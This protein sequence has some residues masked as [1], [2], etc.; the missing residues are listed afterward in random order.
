MAVRTPL[1]IGL[2]SRPAKGLVA[3]GDAIFA[4]EWDGQVLLAI[5]DGLGHGEE[6]ARVSGAAKDWLL[7]NYG[8]DVKEIV[9]MLHQNLRATRGVAVALTK[10]DRPHRSLSFCGIGNVEVRVS[11]K[12]A[13][14]PASTDGI[15]GMSVRKVVKFEY[16]YD[17]LDFLILHSDGISS[18]FN[19]AD[20]P[21]L[22][23]DPQKA[24]EDI[25]RVFGKDYDDASIIIAVGPDNR[26]L[27]RD[28]RSVRI[29]NAADAS[30]AAETAKTLARECG[31][32]ETDQT[33]IAIAVSELGMNIVMHAKGEGSIEISRLSELKRAG[34]KVRATDHGP[35]IPDSEV[36]SGPRYGLGIGLGAVQR[37]MDETN[38]QTRLEVGTTI[39]AKK[40]TRSD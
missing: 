3:N 31:F 16:K 34:I 10:V 22:H 5:I 19:I 26:E 15:V 6:A 38:I 30:M 11:G 36:R 33:K 39:T 9:E 20:Y 40:W 18:G 24:A 12:P 25:A 37:L 13:M 32:S 21:L 7:T 2:Y 14:H 1:R 8:H 17:T 35:G 28:V 23:E 4:Q 27:S 29:S